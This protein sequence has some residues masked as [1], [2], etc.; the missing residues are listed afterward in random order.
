MCI[1]AHVIGIL[2]NSHPKKSASVQRHFVTCVTLDE[3]KHAKIIVV[4]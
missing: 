4:K 1:L 2:N 3:L